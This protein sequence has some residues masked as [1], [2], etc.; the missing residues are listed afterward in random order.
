MFL[1]CFVPFILIIKEIVIVS[2]CFK[3]EGFPLA[4]WFPKLWGVKNEESDDLSLSN[5]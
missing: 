5:W 1:S 2:S 4:Q 3:V